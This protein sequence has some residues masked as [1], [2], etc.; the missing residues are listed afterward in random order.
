MRFPVNLERPGQLS[1][2]RTEVL[3]LLG[4]A[5]VAA[6][7]Y[8]KAEAVASRGSGAA[9]RTEAEAVLQLAAHEAG[10]TDI[11]GAVKQSLKRALGYD[12]PA[13]YIDRAIGEA[14]IAGVGG[15]AEEKEAALAA[16]SCLPEA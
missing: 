9:A 12:G 7:C 6:V 16:W 3:G 8:K 11:H 10:V 14:E 2:L 5:N 1:W 13:R 15:S 4:E